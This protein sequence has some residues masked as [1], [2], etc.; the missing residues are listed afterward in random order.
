MAD[1]IASKQKAE[2]VRNA[3][4]E[5]LNVRSLLRKYT[6]DYQIDDEIDKKELHR[7]LKK[8]AK[9]LI[10]IFEEMGLC[11][12]PPTDISLIIGH[13]QL[14]NQGS[15]T[16]SDNSPIKILETGIDILNS[17]SDNFLFVGSNAAKKKLK[18]IGIE[19]IRIIVAGG[20]INIEEM[21]ELNPAMPEA[22][23]K[24]Y[25]KKLENMRE[26]LKRAFQS[27]KKV[28]FIFSA[29][30][31]TDKMILKRL[32]ELENFIGGKFDPLPIKSWEK[33]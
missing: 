20:P 27:G 10:P 30:D 28:F 22:G 8:A 11:V 12:E 3:L 15:V 2:H 16:K 1:F 24:N 23:L 32:I 17:V 26:D 6:P 31:N 25:E 29:L 19:P 18:G 14:I 4:E 33:I 13:T 5:L 7:A 21:K 9:F